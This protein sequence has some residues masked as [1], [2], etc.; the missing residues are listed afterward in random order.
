LVERR[1]TLQPDTPDE[2]DYVYK[3]AKTTANLP[4]SVD[5]R[6]YLPPVYDQG[7]LG[8]CTANALTAFREYLEI[9][10]GKAVDPLSRLFVYWH[11]REIEGTVNTDSGASLR[12]GMKVLAKIGV[13]PES[14]WPYVEDR[15]AEK[16][17]E[18]AEATAGKYRIAEYHRVQ[19]VDDL[20]AA[21]ASGQPVV[22]GILVWES[23]ESTGKDG[24]VP[25][26]S[27]A[28]GDKPLGGHAM[29]ACGYKTINGRRYVLLRN[30]W[31]PDWGD[32]GYCWMPPEYVYYFNDMWT[33]VARVTPDNFTFESAIDTIVK[34][35][36]FDSPE[37]W[38]TFKAKYDAGTLTNADFE[39]VFLGF[40]KFAAYIVNNG[41]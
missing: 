2:R 39:Y 25:A 32:G 30:S 11:E 31:G 13:C 16:P 21:L 22:V 4:D 20:F 8:S 28:T 1:Y 5:L 15:F 17:S 18:A 35:G 36:V 37:F 33:G 38:R 26:T 6:P 9:K 24:I 19:T 7:Y 27:P 29:L 34:A 41:A 3:A 14:V 12:D 40:R 10:D 23:F